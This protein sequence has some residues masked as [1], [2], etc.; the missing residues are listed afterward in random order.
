MLQPS[1]ERRK[2][3]TLAARGLKLAA[4]FSDRYATNRMSSLASLGG[5]C[6]KGTAS[7]AS[8]YLLCKPAI[9]PPLDRFSQAVFETDDLRIAQ[10]FDS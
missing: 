9:P 1:L 4:T 7:A 2:N 3:Y 10:R 5:D 6:R 8:N